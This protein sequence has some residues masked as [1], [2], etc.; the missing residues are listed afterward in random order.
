[1]QKSEI[2]NIAT[3]IFIFSAIAALV[4]AFAA[5]GGCIDSAGTTRVLR[6]QGYSEVEITGWRPL[7]CGKDDTFATGFRAK[8]PSGEEVTGVVTRGIF[9]GS[10][11]RLD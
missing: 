6:Q 7:S 4:V 3:G 2:K 10:T 8:S 5:N 11:V 9:K 1:M